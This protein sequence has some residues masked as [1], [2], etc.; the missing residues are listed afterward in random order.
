MFV[1]ALEGSLHSLAA[2]DPNRL[3][4]GVGHGSHPA[5]F[6]KPQCIVEIGN[7]AEELFRHD[8]EKEVVG[9]CSQV[10]DA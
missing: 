6:S 1:H 3:F 2:L 9:Q 7:L 8:V 5:L 10:E 4:H